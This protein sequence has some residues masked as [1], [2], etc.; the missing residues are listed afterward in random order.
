MM[1]WY[2]V[3]QMI[4]HFLQSIHSAIHL[5]LQIILVQ[6]GKEYKFINSVPQAAAM[7]FAFYSVFILLL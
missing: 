2:G 7:T 4:I 3:N 5:F 6:N 1:V